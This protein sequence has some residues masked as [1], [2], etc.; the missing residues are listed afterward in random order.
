MN[1][2][3]LLF[4]VFFCCGTIAQSQQGNSSSTLIKIFNQNSK[5][6]LVA[7]DGLI[8]DL[9]AKI[10]SEES[11]LSEKSTITDL[12]LQHFIEKGEFLEFKK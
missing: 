1:K 6:S 9:R 7:N 11:T 5:K 10:N 4:I 12:M 8:T 2:I 3:I